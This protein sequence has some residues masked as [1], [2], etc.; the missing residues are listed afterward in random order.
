MNVVSESES[1][2]KFSRTLACSSRAIPF[3]F[4]P[5]A[6]CQFLNQDEF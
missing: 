6:Q 1:D 3:G 2:S 5:F 4:E